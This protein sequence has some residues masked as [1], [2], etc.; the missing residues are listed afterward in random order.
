MAIE[1]GELSSI[2]RGDTKRI[3]L[4]PGRAGGGQVQDPETI[5]LSV[6][7]YR[8]DTVEYDAS[9]MQRDG[10][11]YYVDHTF[12]ASGTC[13]ITATMTDAAG[14]HETTRGVVSVRS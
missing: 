14:R 11:D 2:D 7:E 5:T 8:Q 12:T 9:D 10:R 13:R 3:T 1:I 4:R 6:T